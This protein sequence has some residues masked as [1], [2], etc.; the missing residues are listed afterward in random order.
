MK[1]NIIKCNFLRLLL[2]SRKIV[3]EIT[4]NCKLG[5]LLMQLMVDMAHVNERMQ[6]TNYKQT[7]TQ[8]RFQEHNACIRIKCSLQ[9]YKGF[10]GKKTMTQC[11][12][13]HMAVQPVKKISLK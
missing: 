4:L 11:N 13:V 7:S 12:N 9:I 10:N 6:Q 2:D 1:E 8:S 5:A 3:T